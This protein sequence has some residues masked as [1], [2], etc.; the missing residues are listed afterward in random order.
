MTEK[1]YIKELFSKGLQD[2][3]VSV[4]PA[5]WSSISSSIGASTAKA[6]L[7]ILTKALIGVAASSVI[8]VAVYFSVQTNSKAETTQ[9][10]QLQNQKETKENN[11]AQKSANTHSKEKIGIEETKVILEQNNN[12]NIP[13][14]D[15]VLNIPVLQINPTPTQNQSLAPSALIPQSISANIPNNAIS[16][17]STPSVAPRPNINSQAQAQVL[18][19]QY[20]ISLPNIFTPNSDGQNETLQIEW[21]QQQIEDFS[22]VVLNQTNNVIFSSSNPEFSWD[23]TDP[24]GEKIA[25]GTYI[26]FV[27][28]MLNGQKWQQSSSL[29]IQ[30]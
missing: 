22:I 2:H 14:E 29:Q 30:Y 23:A 1:D 6:G 3:Q 13:T 18:P 17:T 21:K 26:Y 27:T 8:A 19:K 24:S 12:V 4:D 11:P 9:N 28:G 16:T 5:L 25:R 15:T 7:S 20:R 10:K